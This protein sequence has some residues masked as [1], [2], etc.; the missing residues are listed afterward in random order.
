MRVMLDTNVI[1][2]C[3]VRE[4]N[5]QPRVGKPLSERLLAL[6]DI[7]AHQGLVAWHSLPIIAYY[8]ERQNTPSDTASMMDML[9]TM[10]EVPR[11]GHWDAENWR[12]HNVADFEDALQIASA[13]AG[14]A[15][16]FV[17]WNI[18]DFVGCTIPVLTPKE[19]LASCP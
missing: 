14:R 5:G 7:G 19:F 1:L 4:P 17:S 11:V 15:D 13:R 2:D 6:C 3:L 10:L 9:I 12:S 8:H 18:R 16:V